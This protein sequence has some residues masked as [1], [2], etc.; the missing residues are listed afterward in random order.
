MNAYADTI[1]THIG[2]SLKPLV[3]ILE[4]KQ[5]KV[6]L[7]TFTSGK[8]IDT[9]APSKSINSKVSAALTRAGIPTVIA[10]RAVNKDA[11]QAEVSRVTKLSGASYVILGTYE[12]TG[13]KF[14][15]ECTVFDHNGA[16]VG[17]CADM[18]ATDI[19][20][21]VAD[22]INCPKIEKEVTP[23]KINDTRNELDPVPVS[24][25]LKKQ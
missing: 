3:K 15:L 24:D 2:D 12:I 11:E 18:P 5:G 25:T 1:E 19:T 9:C 17:A 13:L 21:E 20:Q 6:A 22:S 4:V 14:K 8:I 7:G 23:V 10:S 16:G